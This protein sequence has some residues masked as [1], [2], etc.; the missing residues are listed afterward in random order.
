MINVLEKTSG[1]SI[2]NYFIK[3]EV[4]K[5]LNQNLTPFFVS[6]ETLLRCKKSFI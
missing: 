4:F 2:Q 3:T 1:E 6:L 5:G